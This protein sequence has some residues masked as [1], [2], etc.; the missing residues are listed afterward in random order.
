MF[1]KDNTSDWHCTNCGNEEKL[2]MNT[3]MVDPFLRNLPYGGSVKIYST[4]QETKTANIPLQNGIINKKRRKQLEHQMDV[5]D[6]AKALA[7][8][9]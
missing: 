7:L 6:S 3:E 1:K 5:D 9:E 4:E 8:E 2:K